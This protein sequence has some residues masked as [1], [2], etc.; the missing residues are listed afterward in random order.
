ILKEEKWRHNW[1]LRR[2]YQR[3]RPSLYVGDLDPEVMEMELI[4]AFR[5]IGPVASVRICRDILSNRSLCYGY[6]NFLSHSDASK[7]IACLNHTQFKG[8]PMRLMWCQRD[9]LKRKTGVG[10]LF[11][12]NLDPSVTS[13][14]LEGVFCKFGTILSCKVAEEHGKS[15]GFG[16]VQFDSEDS[17]MAALNAL[18]DT[19][20]EGKK[21]YVSKFVMK[22]QRKDA[23]EE[24]KFTNLYVK[25]LSENVTEDVLKDKFS[26]F[27]KVCNVLIM[28]DAD[29]K[30]RGFGFVNFELHEEAKKAVE[31][32][33][34]TLLGSEKLFVGKAQKKAEREELLKRE[35]KER[36]NCHAEKPKASN[37]YVKNLDGSINDKILAEHFRG[38]GKVTSAKVMRYDNGISKGFGFVSFSNPEDAKKAL[39]AFHGTIFRGR[40]L[41]VSIAQCKEERRKELLSYYAQYP[42][43]S[44][45]SP[46]FDIL[47]PRFHPTY[48]SFPPHSTPTPVSSHLTSYQLMMMNQYLRSGGTLYPLTSQSYQGNVSTYVPTRQSQQATYTDYVFQHP[49][50]YP[51][52]GILSTRQLK[53]ET[54]MDQKISRKRSGAAEASSKGFVSTNDLTPASSLGNCKEN[55]GKFLHPPAKNLQPV[56]STKITGILMESKNTQDANARAIADGQVAQASQSALC[57][58]H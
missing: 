19:M 56:L 30:S 34:G 51:N 55:I 8:K 2:N 37:L 46:N 58:S 28:K 3:K 57:L 40:S 50:R 22:S 35:S 48:Y 15:K 24:P 26:E 53:Y 7:A 17:S 36:I 52:S 21:L 14:C 27:G 20:L 23:Q 16:F 18:H 10:N 9:P 32:L 13:A 29:G 42:L 45:Y 41:Y 38:F 49:M 11:V 6:I 44:F 39:H 43:G 31:A 4:E 33:N 47:N 54:C 5:Q 1:W 12:K 25:N